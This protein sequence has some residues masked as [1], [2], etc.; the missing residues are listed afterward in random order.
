MGVTGAV[1]LHAESREVYTRLPKVPKLSAS[2]SSHAKRALVQVICITSLVSLKKSLAGSNTKT[3]LRD[4]EVK[5]QL[6]T[7]FLS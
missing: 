6:V 4:P 1:N 2:G 5:P 3:Q 7:T